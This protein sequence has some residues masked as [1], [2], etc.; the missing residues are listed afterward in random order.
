[1]RFGIREHLEKAR[2]ASSMTLDTRAGKETRRLFVPLA[3]ILVA[4]VGLDYYGTQNQWALR[5]HKVFQVSFFVVLAHM[6][7]SEIFPYLDLRRLYENDD[8]SFGLV[9]IGVAIL[10]A[11]IILGGTLGL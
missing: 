5:L 10:M 9:F 8:P 3:W 4:L 7:R 11:A 1:M 6:I 2:T